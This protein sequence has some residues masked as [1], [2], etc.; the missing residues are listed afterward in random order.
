MTTFQDKVNVMID[1][2]TIEQEFE[3]LRQHPDLSSEVIK[4]RQYFINLRQAEDEHHYR[5]LKSIVDEI[6]LRLMP[7]YEKV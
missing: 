4:V 3:V 7:L 2:D 1:F 5:R 6:N